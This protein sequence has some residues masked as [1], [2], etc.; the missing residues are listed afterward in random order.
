M[1]PEDAYTVP[2]GA[3]IPLIV[4]DPEMVDIDIKGYADLWDPS[5]RRIALVPTTV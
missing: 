1:T 4:Y 5:G 3:G 2:Y